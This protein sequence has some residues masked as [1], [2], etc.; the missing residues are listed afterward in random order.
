MAALLQTIPAGIPQLVEPN[1][2]SICKN[3]NRTLRSKRLWH[4]PL[5]VGDTFPEH[6]SVGAMHPDPYVESENTMRG[7]ENG[8]M[9]QRN[10]DCDQDVPEHCKHASYLS[11]AVTSDR[12][13]A[14]ER[15]HW[16]LG[17]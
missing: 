11:R 16:C 7:R 13:F 15:I 10:N 8:F 1:A 3:V 9:Q 17:A 14:R 6:R 5:V 4:W 2:C 12:L